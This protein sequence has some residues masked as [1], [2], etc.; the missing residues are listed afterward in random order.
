MP[1]PEDTHGVT[2]LPVIHA[3]PGRSAP[4]PRQAKPRS[5]SR[6][7]AANRARAAGGPTADFG[8]SAASV[9]VLPAA[10]ADVQE[11]AVAR[12]SSSPKA[13][14]QAPSFGEAWEVHGAA[15]DRPLLEEAAGVL[16][17]A[18]EAKEEFPEKPAVLPDGGAGGEAVTSDHPDS[19]A[20]PDVVLSVPEAALP[21][22]AADALAGSAAGQID[23][24]GHADQQSTEDRETSD[25]VTQPLLQAFTDPFS[26]EF[27]AVRGRFGEAMRWD[28]GRQRQELRQEFNS[29]EV[30]AAILIR[31]YDVDRSG[32]LEANEV[33]SLLQDYNRGRPVRDDELRFVMLAADKNSDKCISKEELL[34]ALKVW[35]AFKHMP[36]SVGASLTRYKIGGGPPPSVATLRECM[37]TL[38]DSL[39]VPTDEVHRVLAAATRFGGTDELVTTQQMR[40]AIATW[41]LHLQRN[42]TAHLQLA[43]DAHK[44]ALR[45]LAQG[46]NVVQELVHGA[47]EDDVLDAEDSLLSGEQERGTHAMDRRRLVV[48]FALG[49]AS[50]LLALLELWVGRND[51]SKTCEKKLAGL[52]YFTGVI[53]LLASILN[54]GAFIVF[55]LHK[56]PMGLSEEWIRQLP[57]PLV[58]TALVAVNILH[59]VALITG[60]SW[61]T[62]SSAEQCG[63]FLWE[64]CSFVYVMLPLLLAFAVA[65]GPCCCYC[66][67]GAVHGVDRYSTDRHLMEP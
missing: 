10:A 58:P 29:H 18:D 6:P 21:D 57:Q 26:G 51:T 59:L 45:R 32:V 41:Y 27:E 46:V 40:K 61:V 4:G 2:E 34:Y 13:R 42:E 24:Q 20:G 64:T 50:M 56:R 49:V 43:G 36:K 60:F 30:G 22:G 19:V 53:L 54:C 48:V 17:V 66:C 16:P 9:V 1:V 55:A 33:E 3:F 44:V 63:V 23:A 14:G 47:R 8:A 35:Y 52:L 62:T 12:T 7:R 11:E 67:L 28:C 37:V 5:L 15:K 25:S 31:R 65:C 39:P 38:N